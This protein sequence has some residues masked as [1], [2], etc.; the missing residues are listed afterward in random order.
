M[1]VPTYLL[2]LLH[3]SLLN[4]SLWLDFLC[5]IC[6]LISPTSNVLSLSS[7][8]G[9]PIVWQTTALSK[10]LMSITSLPNYWQYNKS[11]CISSTKVNEIDTWKFLLHS[12]NT[13]IR[14]HSPARFVLN[15]NILEKSLFNVEWVQ[16]DCW[17]NL[18]LIKLCFS[19]VE[20][21]SFYFSNACSKRSR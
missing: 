15:T 11:L 2:Q 8:S 18:P 17:I 20:T 12:I 19:K 21:S 3:P 10:E 4:I 9:C 5:Y 14:I 7:V 1:D 16:V 6:W 13:Q